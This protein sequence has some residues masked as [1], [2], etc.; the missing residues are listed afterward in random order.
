MN[1][2]L[3][4]DCGKPVLEVE[5]DAELLNWSEAIRV[6]YLSHGIRPGS[7][8]VIATPKRHN[9]GLPVGSAVGKMQKQAII[10]SDNAC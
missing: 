1:S 6:A 4:S 2:V 8:L 9:P 10:F 5:Y 7:V 3:K